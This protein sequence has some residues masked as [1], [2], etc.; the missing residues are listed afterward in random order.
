MNVFRLYSEWYIYQISK[1]KIIGETTGTKQ[2]AV[3]V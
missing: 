1:N 3:E 2:A